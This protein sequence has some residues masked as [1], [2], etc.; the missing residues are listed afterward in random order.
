[1]TTISSTNVNTVKSKFV[2]D[3]NNTKL[4][5][6][7]FFY[8][9]YNIQKSNSSPYYGNCIS[10]VMVRVLA[11]C[12]VDRGFEPPSG[13]PKTIKLEFVAAPLSTQH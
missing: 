10:G 6:Q 11:L 13:Q 4:N 12:V 1:V 7:M 3:P 5:T 2:S 9:Y 8:I